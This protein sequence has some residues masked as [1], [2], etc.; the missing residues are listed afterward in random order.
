MRIFT[1][2][3]FLRWSSDSVMHQFV[4]GGFKYNDKY[5]YALILFDKG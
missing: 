5:Q 4:I 2:A 1:L 3:M